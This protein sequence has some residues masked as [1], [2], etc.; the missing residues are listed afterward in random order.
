MKL[1]NPNH[2][3][4]R[5]EELF[6]A[7]FDPSTQLYWIT[8]SI[9]APNPNSFDHPVISVLTSKETYELWH[10]RLGHAGKGAI[11]QLPDH[12]IGVPEIKVPDTIKPCPGCLAGK[13][14]RIPH[15][16]S[17]TRA[18]EQLGLIHMDL[19]EMLSYA[20][21]SKLKWTVTCLDDY[22]SYG[23]M[24]FISDK[25]HTTK[26]FDHFVTWA[27]RQLGKKVKIVRVDRGGE[28]EGIQ[29]DPT[30]NFKTYCRLHGIDIQSALPRTQEQNGRAERWQQTIEN[31]SVSD[32]ETAGLTQGFWKIAIEHATYVYNH[33]PFS[34]AEWRTPLELWDGT[35]P[36]ISNFRIFGCKAF[37][38]VHKDKR[39]KLQS[40]VLE[41]TFIGYAQINGSKGYRVWLPQSRTIVESC[42]VTFD[43]SPFIGQKP[44]TSNPLPI[45]SNPDESDLVNPE[46]STPLIHYYD[47][48]TPSDNENQ[49]DHLTPPPP[50][51]PEESDDNLYGDVP[52]LKKEEEEQ[53]IPSPQDPPENDIPFPSPSSP[54]RNLAP[55][56]RFR[57]RA[58][59]SPAPA[60]EPVLRRSARANTGQNPGRTANSTYGNRPAALIQRDTTAGNNYLNRDEP[61]DEDLFTFTGEHIFTGEEDV[62]LDTVQAML[63]QR[64]ATMVPEQYKDAQRDP[65]WI[66]WETAI[67]NEYSSL[68]E[69]ETW[70]KDLAQLP[71]GRK[72]VKCRWVFDIKN[73]G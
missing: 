69:M 71:K 49:D 14:K 10:Q 18:T 43:E 26:C 39:N 57:P 20:I 32:L 66:K 34:R 42:D 1:Y 13:A 22:S 52:D 29:D 35:I 73:D 63:T 5:G 72:A 64:L 68:I 59:A 61:V 28:F 56:P 55:P 45:Q 41:G 19:D 31:K 38:H 67:N 51:H 6:S 25:S 50:E 33:T 70:D 48:D 40:K 12:V 21:G 54:P 9:T 36:D 15:P 4:H 17:R 53:Q 37:V 16:P 8:A 3:G 23:K 7:K 27:E 24:Y 58:P 47:D 62:S 30:S 11:K 60:P 65:N 2:K 46:L 44:K